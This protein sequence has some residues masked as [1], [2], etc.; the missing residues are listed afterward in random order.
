M[1]TTVCRMHSSYAYENYS[2]DLN[3]QEC[4]L[5]K[6][7][8]KKALPR[9]MDLSSYDGDAVGRHVATRMKTDA[10]FAQMIRS[11]RVRYLTD[12][13]RAKTEVTIRDGVLYQ[14][15]LDSTGEPSKLPEGQYVFVINNGKLFATPKV[16]TDTGRIQHSSFFR[17]GDVNSAGKLSVDDKGRI[18]EVN[19]E[20]GHYKPG[21]AH[22]KTAISYLSSLEAYKDM[23]PN[24]LE[25]IAKFFLQIQEFFKELFNYEHPLDVSAYP[26]DMVHVMPCEMHYL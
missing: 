22:L 8:I 21:S 3:G 24:V 11:K 19:R 13:D 6:G 7:L 10:V 5:Y 25:E 1:N 17:G 12:A 16:M 14:I 4:R 20:S 2:F 26:A 18:T 9:G 23:K 15:G